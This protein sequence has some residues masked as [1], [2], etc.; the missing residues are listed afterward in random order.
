VSNSGVGTDVST[1][2][3]EHRTGKGHSLPLDFQAYYLSHQAFFHDFTEIH[4]G[5]RKVAER[6]VH[7]V[8]LE[9]LE[10][11]GELLQHDDIEQQ[12]LA[13][14]HRHVQEQL[15]RENRPAAFVINGPIARNLRAVRCQLELAPS[16]SGLYEAILDLP[17]RQFTV[18]VLRHLLGYPTKRIARYMGLDPRTVDYHGRKGRERL[19][20]QLG[21]PETPR[22]TKTEAS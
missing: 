14:L 10:V 19:R 15:R 20:V 11:W 3:G 6:V 22:K 4:L 12:T 9:V 16:N 8:F 13:V 1:Q 5:S 7:D 21:L 18:I 2:N 17:T